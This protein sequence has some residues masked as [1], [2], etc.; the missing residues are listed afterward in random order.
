M[1]EERLPT[2]ARFSPSFHLESLTLVDSAAANTTCQ[3]PWPVGPDAERRQCSSGHPSPPP[4]RPREGMGAPG[5]CPGLCPHGAC[6]NGGLLGRHIWEGSQGIPCCKWKNS[7]SLTSSGLQ[8][9]PHL[10]CSTSPPRQ[11]ALPS[12]LLLA[13]SAGLGLV[14]PQF[15]SAWGERHRGVWLH[16]QGR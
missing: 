4:C 13:C 7:D 8:V 15:P 11:N 14:L 16:L 1:L 6:L 9:S 10:L 2:H 3:G 5:E 12:S